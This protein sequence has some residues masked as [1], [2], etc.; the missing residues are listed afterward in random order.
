MRITL[1]SPGMAIAVPTPGC[2]VGWLLSNLPFV[3]KDDGYR[4]HR[5]LAQIFE[6]PGE[7]DH[8]RTFMLHLLAGHR[9]VLLEVT[10]NDAAVAIGSLA[11][12]PLRWNHRPFATRDGRDARLRHRVRVG[13]RH[14]GPR[15]GLKRTAL[16]VWQLRFVVKPPDRCVPHRLYQMD[17][18]LAGFMIC[19]SAVAS[20]EP[21]GAAKETKGECL[22]GIR[23]VSQAGSVQGDDAND[24]AFDD[25]IREL[26]TFGHG[27][28]SAV[29]SLEEDEDASFA[30]EKASPWEEEEEDATFAEAEDALHTAEGAVRAAT[31][32]APLLHLHR[33][34]RVAS[35][36]LTERQSYSPL[37]FAPPY[38]GKVKPRP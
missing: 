17:S 29:A 3:N 31:C 8:N 28:S 19:E 20:S 4:L 22:I 36:A 2:P 5:G 10:N 34:A 1:W 35:E 27:I 12:S 32:V 11:V 16:D 26:I 24:P 7:H 38:P 13:H 23:S 30:E 14:D 15:G 33:A 25:A 6:A 9:R 37:V 21:G 18:T